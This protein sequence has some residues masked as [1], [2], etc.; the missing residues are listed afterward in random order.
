MKQ[1]YSWLCML[2]LLPIQLFAQNI[3]V[4]GKITNSEGTPLQSVTVTIVRQNNQQPGTITNSKGEYTLQ[5]GNDAKA[6]LFSYTGMESVTEPINGRG[7]VDVQMSTAIKS[8]DQVVVVGYGTQ[9]RSGPDWCCRKC[10]SESTC[11]TS[12]GEC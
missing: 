6:L 10:K 3:V 11:R 12:F 4:K 9:K 1:I 2:A 5:V 8:L 7:T